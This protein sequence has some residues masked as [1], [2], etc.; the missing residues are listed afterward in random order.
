[1]SG[2]VRV[3]HVALERGPCFLQCCNVNLMTFH[4]CQ[5]NYNAG[6]VEGAV[7]NVVPVGDNVTLLN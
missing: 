2:A 7:G 1:M 5:A 3:E 4:I 6:I